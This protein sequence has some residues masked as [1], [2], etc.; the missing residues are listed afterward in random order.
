MKFK[1]ILAAFLA[2]NLLLLSGCTMS[3]LLTMPEEEEQEEPIDMAGLVI[4]AQDDYYGYVNKD[5]LLATEIEYGQYSAGSFNEALDEVENVLKEKLAE[6]VN[7]KE[8]FEEGSSEAN[9]KLAY[10]QYVEFAKSD[11]LKNKAVDK[12][13]AQMDEIMNAATVNELLEVGK[14]LSRDYGVSLLPLACDI[15]YSA[16]DEYAI[17]FYQITDV[18]GV[19]LED[20]YEDD[21]YAS[22][23]EDYT[24]CVL[25]A[26]GVEQRKAE[27]TAKDLAYLA[28]ELAQNTDFEVQN[29]VD[30]FDTIYFADSKS[31]DEKLS[32]FTTG[33]LEKYCGF[34]NNPYGG[35]AVQDEEQIACYVGLLTE[36]N[37]DVLKAWLLADFVDVYGD[38]LAEKYDG[39]GMYFDKIDPEISEEDAIDIVRYYCGNECG[40]IYTDAVYT[41]EMDTVLR[42]MCESIKQAYRN[43]ISSAD[44]LTKE[45]RELLLQK[46]E[47]IVI[48]TGSDSRNGQDDDDEFG[49]DWFDSIIIGNRAFYDKTLKMVGTKRDKLVPGMTM[50]TVNA[51]YSPDN[52]VTITVAIMNAPFFDVNADF[53]ENLGGLGSVIAHE[54]GHAF[55]SNGMNWDMNGYRNTNWLP[56]SDVEALQAKNVVAANY[57]ET[58][59]KVF[60]VYHVD[61]E[62]TL[63]ENYAD[64]GGMECIM[65]LCETDAQRKTVFEHYAIIW[66]ELVTENSVIQQIGIDVHSPAVIRVNAVLATIP[67]FYSTYDVK[68]GD[69]M[70]IAPENRISR[71]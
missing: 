70:F 67:E 1:K 26:Y 59:F 2:A 22:Y 29:A 9:F 45:G 48:L 11:V 19:S 32:G 61:G 49:D 35:W 47:N 25:K 44:W 27:Q 5:A 63:G 54:I 31:L 39:I 62:K 60:D 10:E 43:K 36:E 6:I 12:L 28:I 14:K 23:I 17:T 57:F 52:T 34:K 21:Y 20:I 4:R 40:N 42:E 50:D 8:E 16:P 66:R 56:S 51:C 46:L 3:D 13:V 69:G 7:S 53:Y 68:D 24:K 38:I 65:T 18:T 55:D 64:L 33:D 71:W 37:L 41:E 15:D 58:S 30:V